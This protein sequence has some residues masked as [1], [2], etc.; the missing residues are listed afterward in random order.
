MKYRL[1]DII[2]GNARHGDGNADPFRAE[3]AFSLR[4]RLLQIAA[5][6][7]FTVVIGRLV[8]IQVI[9]FPKYRQ[10]AQRQYQAKV[11]LPAARGL[12]YDRN[13]S[14]V[15]SNTMNVS[16]AADPQIAG[17]DARAIAT[18]FSKLFGKSKNYY[19]NKLQSDSRF[20]WLERQTDASI[21]KTINLSDVN[22]VVVRNEPKRLYYHDKVAGQLLGTTDID[23]NGLAG[24]ELEYDEILHGTDGYVIFQRDG[25]G[26]ARPSVDY[27]RVE[28]TNGHNIVLTID[29]NLQAVAEKEL[30]KGVEQSSAERGLVVILQPKTGEVLALAQ[31]PSLDP[32]FFN[33]SLPDDQ[34]LRAVT[35]LFE[36]GSVFKIVTASSALE[37]D[38]VTPTKKFY[39]EN[40]KYIVPVANGKPRIISDTHKEGWIT[41]QEAMEYSSNIVMAKVSDLIGPER[42]YTM[43]R[44]YGFGIATGID[45][46]GEAKGTLKKPVDWSGTTLNAI[47]YGYEVAVTPLQIASA[48]ASVANNG[49]LMKPFLFKRE[50]DA[51][52][53]IIK[54]SQPQSIRQVVSSSTINTL[55]E[56]LT[57]VVEKGTGKAAAIPGLAIA[58]KTGTS[59]KFLNGHYENGDYT[60]SFV[61]FFPVDDPQMVCLVMMDNPRGGSYYGG[62]TSAPV[63]RA[64]VEQYR[65]MTSLTAPRATTAMNSNP[66]SSS[67]INDSD[68]QSSPRRLTS[69]IKKNIVRVVSGTVPDVKGYSVR[70]AVSILSQ[71][72][73]EPVVSGSGIVVNQ[74]PAAG[75]PVKAGARVTLICQPRSAVTTSTVG[76]SLN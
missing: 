46:P 40:G 66:Q 61:G 10:I 75:Q 17:D 55:K 45:F 28:P 48:Y 53:T 74:Y 70:R 8:Q 22:G 19:L 27:P 18:K 16:F 68:S 44:N 13:G 23:N 51:D 60:A 56:L 34:R 38:L 15:A 36:P 42:L 63:F 41:F 30:K 31:Y 54:E 65:N 29:M 33:R 52:G 62:L 6:L 58:G 37:H 47:A 50:M 20:V 11:L 5:L 39:A 2:R 76:M 67:K 3:R 59:K 69:S 25:L 26:R 73:F 43:A 35:D 32:N 21:L 4:L 14:L 72:K 64:I 12:I 9:Q 57:S 7:F 71:G 24:L 1:N 49:I